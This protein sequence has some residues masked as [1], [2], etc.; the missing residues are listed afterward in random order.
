ME[1]CL[2]LAE[3]ES[4]HWLY[5]LLTRTITSER[6]R[7]NTE[8]V[9]VHFSK[10]QLKVLNKHAKRLPID[11]H[12]RLPKTKIQLSRARSELIRGIVQIVI[13]KIDGVVL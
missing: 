4:G 10:S 6:L 3:I 12:G 2:K 8:P 13:D 1:A 9:T 11:R 7:K 5:D